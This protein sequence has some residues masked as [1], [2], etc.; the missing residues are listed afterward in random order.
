MGLFKFAV[1]RAVTVAMIFLCIILLGVVALQRL[2]IDL[3][4]EINLPMAAVMTTYPGAGSEEVES[5]VTE[6][7]EEILG[8]VQGVDSITSISSPNSSMVLVTFN[9][10]MDM[11]FA[12]LQ[13]REKIDMVKGSLPDDAQ[14]PMIYKMDPNMMPLA[15]I[16]VN[17][18]TN[19]AELKSYTE[20]TL[21]PR[22]ERQEGVASVSVMG[23]FD[24]ELH[25]V[26]DPAR[27][28]AYGLS[29]DSVAQ[30]INYANL[31]MSA[32]SVISG[33]KELTVRALGSY[34]SIDDIR[35]VP[36]NLNN[37]SVIYLA[38]IAEVVQAESDED[39]VVRIDGKP[40]IALSIM[41]QSDSN[42]VQV[43]NQITAAL[44]QLNAETE[45]VSKAPL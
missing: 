32:G 1:K 36:I 44:E 20:D 6:P 4:P 35:N 2:S 26:V 16:G 18:G 27:L 24:N 22:L 8:T 5:D 34:T 17:G 25:V 11:D 41:K 33:D 31:D 30:A 43:A 13:M 19:L 28:N 15:V 3:F 14:S 23:G 9:L 29:L 10:G 7:L 39:Y 37:G 21:K 42:T 38:D 45:K 40:A 12:S